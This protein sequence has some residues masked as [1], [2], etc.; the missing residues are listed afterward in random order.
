[1]TPR[2]LA[3]LLLIVTVLAGLCWL[4]NEYPLGPGPAVEVTK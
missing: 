1:M 2:D 3:V 4:C